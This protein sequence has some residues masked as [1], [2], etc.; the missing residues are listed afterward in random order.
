VI[1]STYIPMYEPLVVRKASVSITVLQNG[2]MREVGCKMRHSEDSSLTVQIVDKQFF[3]DRIRELETL[4]GLS[5]DSF[6]DTWRDENARNVIANGDCV[7]YADYS[8]MAFL[9]TTMLTDLLFQDSFDPPTVDRCHDASA[10]RK[11]DRDR[12]FV[13]L[14]DIREWIW[15]SMLNI[16]NVF[17]AP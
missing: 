16:G 8:E 11:P 4:Y 17:G 2:P 13:F 3:L 14:R 12:A 10:D 5:W 7:K 9:C 6:L 15:P 1:L